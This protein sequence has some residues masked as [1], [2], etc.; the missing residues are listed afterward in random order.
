MSSITIDSIYPLRTSVSK[1]IFTLYRH[2]IHFWNQDNPRIENLSLI[3]SLNNQYWDEV[4]MRICYMLTVK[5]SNSKRTPK[6]SELTCFP[7]NL[8]LKQYHIGRLSIN[9]LSSL[10][11][12]VLGY[13]V[14]LALRKSQ[15]KSPHGV[16]VLSMFSNRTEQYT[17]IIL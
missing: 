10:P 1:S 11:S 4:Q 2:I 15:L 16:R 12:S 7:V 9:L 6:I 8:N 5:Y 13:K 3:W 17:R 14:Q